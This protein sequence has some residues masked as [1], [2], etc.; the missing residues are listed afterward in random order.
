MATNLNRTG[1]VVQRLD[2]AERQLHQAETDRRWLAIPIVDRDPSEPGEGQTWAIDE[3]GALRLKVRFA[4]QTLVLSAGAT[5][6]ALVLIPRYAGQ[7]PV[8]DGELI[9]RYDEYP[10]G[11]PGKRERVRL[12]VRDAQRGITFE[13]LGMNNALTGGKVVGVCPS[14]SSLLGAPEAALWVDINSPPLLQ[15]RVVSQSIEYSSFL[16]PT[17]HGNTYIRFR[18]SDPLPANLIN[19]ECWY[20]SVENR[21]KIAKDGSILKSPAFTT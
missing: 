18:A 16:L 10:T 11:S 6:G 13:L 1:R 5:G 14:H 2:S 12:L 9:A 19:G 21:L 17:S 4:G 7:S 3:A 8:L 20:N 15:L